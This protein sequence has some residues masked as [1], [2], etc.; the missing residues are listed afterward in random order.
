MDL[1]N[2]DWAAIVKDYGVVITAGAGLLGIFLTFIFA[3]SHYTRSRKWQL[4][5]KVLERRIKLWDTGIKEVRDYTDACSKAIL[6]VSAFEEALIKNYGV[7]E[8]RKMFEELPDVWLDD[9]IIITVYSF[10]NKELQEHYDKLSD[11]LLTEYEN[12]KNLDYAINN[13]QT[14]D[15]ETIAHRRDT[16]LHDSTHHRV[17]MITILDKLEKSLPK[18]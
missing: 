4:E 5:D 6:V 3:R 10:D 11:L 12:V 16:F 1:A 18:K 2:V 13:R 9:K 8:T 17:R 7:A 15:L 14:L